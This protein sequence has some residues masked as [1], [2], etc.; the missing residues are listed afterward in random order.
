VRAAI[1]SLP[2]REQKVIGLYL[3]R[4]GDDE[5][6]RREIGVNESRVSQLHAR[7]IRRLRMP[8]DS[9][10]R[11]PRR[12]EMRGAILAFQKPRCQGDARSA[13]DGRRRRRGLSDARRRGLTRA[14]RGRRA[15]SRRAGTAWRAS[16]SRSL[17]KRSASVPATSPVTKMTRRA[18]DGR[19]RRDGAVKR[20]SVDRGIFR[21]QIT[22][23]YVVPRRGER[24]FA[25]AA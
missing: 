13:A 20:H 23:S 14:C 12:A 3:L 8:L 25:V 15:A 6:D 16:G 11:R 7:A 5:A 4:R 21:S 10:A 17:E 19:R 18:S 2:L 9:M 24:L 1:A 22:A